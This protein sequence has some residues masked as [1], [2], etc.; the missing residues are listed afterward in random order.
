[1]G[2]AVQQSWRRATAVGPLFAGLVLLN[3][4]RTNDAIES[5]LPNQ[6]QDMVETNLMREISGLVY[7]L[8]CESKAG[9]HLQSIR[10]MFDYGKRFAN[11]LQDMWSAI[12]HALEQVIGADLTTQT[13][14]AWWLVYEWLAC[15]DRQS[16]V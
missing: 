11:Y 1:M 10:G 7:S 3:L 16:V 13:R 15:I 5:V 6:T 4:Q 12:L 2:E 9:L 14:Q 8:K